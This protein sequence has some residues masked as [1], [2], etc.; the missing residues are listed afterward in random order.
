MCVLRLSWWCKVKWPENSVVTTDL[1]LSPNIF[2]LINSRTKNQQKTCWV[3]PGKGVLKFNT[4]DVVEGS[5]GKA[6]IGGVLR[7]YSSKTLIYFSKSAGVVDVMSAEILAL[8]EV[9]KL[10]GESK[11]V[12]KFK[13]VFECDSKLITEWILRPHIAP[14]KLLS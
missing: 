5:V 12:D 14:E 10:F 6:G 11:W 1:V 8:V 9:M 2:S 13:V 7:D 4:D 3:A